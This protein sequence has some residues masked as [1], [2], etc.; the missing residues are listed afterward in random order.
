MYGIACE[1]IVTLYR[2]S[3]PVVDLL[4]HRNDKNVEKFDKSPNMDR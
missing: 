4:F 1:S 3:L 2:F